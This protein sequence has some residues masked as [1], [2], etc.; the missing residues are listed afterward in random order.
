MTYV[1]E[2]PNKMYG[3]YTHGVR[4]ENGV[5]ETDDKTVRDVLVDDFGYEDVTPK[6]EKPKSKAEDKPAKDSAK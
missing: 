1:I 6:A 3:G 5:G 4:F 2:A